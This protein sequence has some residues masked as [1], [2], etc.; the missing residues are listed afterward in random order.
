MALPTVGVIVALPEEFDALR[1]MIPARNI[2]AAGSG[3]GREY[4]LGDIPSLRKGAHQ[5]VVAQTMDMGNTSAATRASKMLM[6]FDNIEHIIMCGI[7]GGV[8]H[9]SDA[10]STFGLA[11]S[12]SQTVRA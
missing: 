10:Q 6:D 9:P 1:A 12:W 5:V 2:S 3:G 8:P 11:I 4:L 7:A